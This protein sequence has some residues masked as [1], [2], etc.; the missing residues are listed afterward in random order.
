[1]T[2]EVELRCIYCTLLR[3]HLLSVW[4]I[5]IVHITGPQTKV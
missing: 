5:K 2:D 1:M 4:F 3:T